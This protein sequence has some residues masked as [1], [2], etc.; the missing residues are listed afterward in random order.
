MIDLIFNMQR[1]DLRNICTDKNISI[2]N[3]NITV[4]FN[5]DN[6]TLATT[7]NNFSWYFKNVKAEQLIQNL[8]N[9]NINFY[10]QN[11]NHKLLNNI[12]KECQSDNHNIYV[13]Y[14]NVNTKQLSHNSLTTNTQDLIVNMQHVSNFIVTSSQVIISNKEIKILL[15]KYVNNLVIKQNNV[16]TYFRHAN[17][18]QISKSLDNINVSFHI[19]KSTAQ[20]IYNVTKK[21]ES[22]DCNIYV[23]NYNSNTKKLSCNSLVNTESIAKQ[24]N[25]RLLDDAANL[26]QPSVSS[27]NNVTSL[28]YSFLDDAENLKQPSTSSLNNVTSIDAQQLNYSFLDDAASLKQP[29]TH[30]LADISIEQ[31]NLRA[32]KK[33]S[34]AN[35]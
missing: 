29:S 9:V 23:S 12:I 34:L 17:I 27:L 19:Q 25:Y 22:H 21:F 5:A 13:N 15:D 10:I 32:F 28:N 31:L 20:N 4:Q 8:D 26:K 3:D 11:Y 30:S 18:K 33:P 16:Y 24:S 7:T 35:I 2:A 1:V 14:R 6:K